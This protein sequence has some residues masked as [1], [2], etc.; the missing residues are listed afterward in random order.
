MLNRKKEAKKKDSG[1][2]IRQEKK[3]QAEKNEMTKEELNKA[4]KKYRED[5]GEFYRNLREEK[6]KGKKVDTKVAEGESLA[7]RKRDVKEYNE[8]RKRLDKEVEKDMEKGK[9]PG[10]V[11]DKV[12][13]AK[14][15]WWEKHQR[16]KA[17]ERGRKRA[18]AVKKEEEEKGLF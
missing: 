11:Q 3:E 10:E 7:A 18:E 1:K 13:K 6:E 12:E 5:R 8:F 15:N 4:A 16:G 9:S 17:E 14:R 2:K